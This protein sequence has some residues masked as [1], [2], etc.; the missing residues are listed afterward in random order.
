LTETYISLRHL[1]NK[2][3]G[4]LHHGQVVLGDAELSP[5]QVSIGQFYGIEV[6]D[7]AV[8]VAKTALWIAESQMMK[9]TEGIVHMNLDYLPLKTYANIIEGNALRIDWET[10]I[11]KHKTSYIMGNPPFVGSKMMSNKQRHEMAQ[12]FLN[13][14][15]S[16][17]KG[18]GTLDYVA[19]WYYKASQFINAMRI[20]V[21][22]VSTNSI[23]QGEQV[24]ALWKPV[25]EIF[26]T[27]IDF[28]HRTF[29]WNSEASEKAAVHCVIVGFSSGLGGD[30]VIYDGNRKYLAANINGYLIDAPDVF[31]ESRSK[32][33]CEVPTIGIGN[34]PIDGGNYLFT[35]EEKDE[36]IRKEPQ[37][38][39]WF[40]PWIGADEF[41]NGYRRYCL[42]LGDCPPSELRQ[43]PEALKRVEAVKQF[44]LASKSAPTRKL[45]ETPRRFHVENMPKSNYIVVPKVS[46]EKR[47]YVPMGFLSPDVLSSD[48]VFLIP[49]AALYHFGILTSNVHMAWM[50]AVCG[51]LEMRY[52]Y[53]KDIVY[54]NF[55]WPDVT[56]EQKAVIEK[57]AQGVLDAR[58]LYPESSLADLYDERVMPFELLNAH[59][60]LDRA[61]MKLYGFSVRDFAEADCVS[62]LM[63]MYQKLTEVHER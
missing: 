34:K 22:F 14:N 24:S 31:I 60:E 58:G 20:R 47:R 37:S 59:R 9:E 62:A 43:M 45:A 1:E 50:R 35:E 42:W 27:R 61:V 41:I 30:K 36:F 6:N 19:A 5:I 53:S 46:S 12:T 17:T 4:I 10:V 2:V 29:K 25:F 54:N 49:D 44:R 7:F 48:L 8:T 63:E 16:Q 38:E 11:P 23:T 3:L 55:P 51:R 15:G 13:D 52:R 39:Q 57:L 21:A 56:D 28:A 33:I 26:G 18:S 40:R 32:P